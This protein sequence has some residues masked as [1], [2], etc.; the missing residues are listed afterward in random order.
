MGT[1]TLRA[2][3]RGIAT[4]FIKI[5]KWPRIG[6]QNDQTKIDSDF[7]SSFQFI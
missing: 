1:G 7:I 3:P 6:F 2:K 4:F 5:T